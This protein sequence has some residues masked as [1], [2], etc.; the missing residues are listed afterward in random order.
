[1]QTIFKFATLSILVVLIGCKSTEEKL[2]EKMVACDGDACNEIMKEIVQLPLEKQIAIKQLMMLD[3]AYQKKIKRQGIEQKVKIVFYNADSYIKLQTAVFVETGKTGDF[4]WIGFHADSGNGF[5]IM[6][7][8]NNAFEAVS[9]IE[10]GECPAQTIWTV[11][12]EISN[13]DLNFNC[14]IISGNEDACAKI[15]ENFLALC[16]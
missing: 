3:T 6:E 7:G 16:K 12:P 14:S 15:S 11:K 5:F 13:K 2:A 8:E 4:K 9:Y 10:L 1:M